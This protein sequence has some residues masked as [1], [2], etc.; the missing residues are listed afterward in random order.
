MQLSFINRLLFGLDTRP[1]PSLTSIRK[2]YVNREA[3]VEQGIAPGQEGRVYMDGSWWPARCDRPL[4]LL[5]GTP[6]RVVGMSG[7]T[8]LVEPTYQPF[9]IV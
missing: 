3:R 6:V 2:A 8:L 7:I 9:Y 4:I 1:A 5:P